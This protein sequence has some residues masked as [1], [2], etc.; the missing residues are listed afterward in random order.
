M[1]QQ[2]TSEIERLALEETDLIGP[3]P[4]FFSR[5]RDAYRWHIIVRAP[6]PVVLLRQLPI[7][8]GWRLDI[9]PVDLL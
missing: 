6:D 4:C 5:Q 3:A 8:L 1:A 2:L 7:P 9:D